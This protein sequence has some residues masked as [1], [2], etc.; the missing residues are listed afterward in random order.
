MA[1]VRAS[2]ASSCACVRGPSRFRA[3]STS[4][5]GSRRPAG[6]APPARDHLQGAAP[7][8]ELVHLALDQG[9]GRGRLL[10]PLAKVGFRHGLEVVEVVE[11]HPG[12]LG[13]PGV[14]VARTAMSIRNSGRRR[15]PPT[16]PGCPPRGS[17]PG[18]AVPLITMSAFMSSA[19]SDS[20]GAAVPPRAAASCSASRRCAPRE[21]WPVPRSARGGARPA[22]SSSRPDQ[23]HA[24]VLQLAEDLAGQLHGHVRDGD[25]VFAD[26]RLGAARLAAAIDGLRR[27]IQDRPQ[28]ARPSRDLIGPPSPG[29]GSAAPPGPIESRLAATRKACRTA[30]SPS[31]QLEERLELTGRA[32]V[33][34]GEERNEAGTADSLA[35][36]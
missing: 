16:P 19:R 20:K 17:H 28:G 26:P 8:E 11:E 35:R 4:R 24:P 31:R 27:R 29:P 32:T 15:R 23:E 7:L 3:L 2:R 18:G 21:R 14:D 12:E 1:E 9:L 34:A 5:A 13:G 33:V 10:L 30:A 25:R 36:P 22:R 6:A